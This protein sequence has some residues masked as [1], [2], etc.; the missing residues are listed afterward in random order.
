[1]KN[2][3]AVLLKLYPAGY[4]ALFADEMAEVFEETRLDRRGLGWRSYLLFLITEFAGLVHGAV[5]A[6]SMGVWQSGGARAA[7]P[8]VAGA[9]FSLPFLRPIFYFARYRPMMPSRLSTQD[10]KLELMVLAVVSVVLIAA[11]SA[12]FVLNLRSV[13]Q[14]RSAE[15]ARRHA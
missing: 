7:V 6:R 14:R 1:M 4:R 5:M 10:E 3:F 9:A 13:A 8:F 2:A 15:P 12:A 11:F